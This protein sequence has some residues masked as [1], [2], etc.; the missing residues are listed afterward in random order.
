MEKIDFVVRKWL[1]VSFAPESQIVNLFCPKILKCSYRVP[2]IEA[3]QTAISRTI[4]TIQRDIR[5]GRES[6]RV[7]VCV[8]R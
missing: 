6:S 4:H 7:D 1:S 5:R 2:L 8:E 3:N